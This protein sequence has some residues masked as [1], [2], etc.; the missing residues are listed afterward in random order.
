[1]RKKQKPREVLPNDIEE[2]LRQAMDKNVA[3]DVWST[4]VP[5]SLNAILKT[6]ENWS[7]KEICLLKARH[8]KALN[9]WRCSTCDSYEVQ[10]MV[11]GYIEC[12]SK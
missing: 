9:F 6:C 8:S 5:L 12:P 10:K 7:K 4:I 1:M 11:G 2:T 3:D